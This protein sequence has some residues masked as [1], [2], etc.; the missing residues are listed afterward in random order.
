M[1]SQLSL[2]YLTRSH[3]ERFFISNYVVAFLY[4]WFRSAQDI[5]VKSIN[6][7]P[8]SNGGDSDPSS[9]LPGAN[10]YQQIIL[11]LWPHVAGYALAKG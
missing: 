8:W 9:N 7:M 4:I 1:T 5:V 11:K 2:K 10:Y 6:I 3:P